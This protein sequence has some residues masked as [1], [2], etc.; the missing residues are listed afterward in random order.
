MQKLKTYPTFLVIGAQKSGTSWLAQMISQHPEVSVAPKKEVNFFNKVSN[1]QK[2]LEWYK[3]Q[4]PISPTTKAVGEFTPN[5]LWTS[6]D[7]KEIKE[8]QRTRNI[9]KLVHDAYPNIQLIVCLRNPTDRA[10]SA[11]YHHIRKGRVSPKQSIV[12]VAEHYGIKSM[13]NYD[14]HLGNWMSYYPPDN[15]RFLI[16][17]EDFQDEK[18]ERP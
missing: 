2:G 11:Y 12:D 7:E 9:P 10:T 13:G 1:Y 16:Y 5:Y 18:K 6:Q 8:S 14:I 3:S 17:E 15:F 4:F